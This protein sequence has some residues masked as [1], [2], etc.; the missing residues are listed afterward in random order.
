[1]TMTM[2]YE[3]LLPWH[4]IVYNQPDIALCRIITVRYN[5]SI[6]DLTSLKWKI[7][8]YF[9]LYTRQE[10]TCIIIWLLYTIK[11]INLVFLNNIMCIC[12][13]NQNIQ[14]TKIYSIILY[15]IALHII[16]CA[17]LFVKGEHIPL[18]NKGWLRLSRNFV[19]NGGLNIITKYLNMFDI[20]LI[21]A[22]F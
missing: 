15:N 8:L 7:I 5:N 12:F 11:V 14:L 4:V 6:N 2:K 9:A 3:I 10:Y 18:W 13:F 21:I 19:E 20:I 16:H 1:M 17:L 22:K